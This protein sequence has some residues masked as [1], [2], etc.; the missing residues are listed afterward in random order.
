[1]A[2]PQVAGTVALMF[3]AAK[4]PLHIDETHRL[5]LGTAQWNPAWEEER[6]RFGSGYL[7]IEG[8]VDAARQARKNP[9]RRL[10][11]DREDLMTQVQEFSSASL[12]DAGRL[13]NVEI[14]PEG[15][16][17]AMEKFGLENLES[18]SRSVQVME[19]EQG[20]IRHE[21]GNGDLLN[22]GYEK[23]Q[24][25]PIE[26]NIGEEKRFVLKV[27]SYTNAR[28]SY[29][30]AGAIDSIMASLENLQLPPG[31]SDD[32]GIYQLLTITALAPGEAR[33]VLKNQE[34]GKSPTA[35]KT[36]L[37]VVQAERIAG[38]PTGG[39]SSL[40]GTGRKKAESELLS[41]EADWQEWE[42]WISKED[43]A[44]EPKSELI[45]TLLQRIEAME[46]AIYTTPL[47]IQSSSEWY[48]GESNVLI[49]ETAEFYEDAECAACDKTDQLPGSMV[50]I[51]DGLIE[52]GLVEGASET[53]I[54]QALSEANVS[55]W[56]PSPAEL[57]DVFATGGEQVLR[58]TMEGLYELVGLP[59]APL[60][61]PIE[62]GDILVRRA[63]GEGSLAHAALVDTPELFA[64]EDLLQEGLT[65]ESYTPGWYT[66]V[67]EGGFLPHSRAHGYARR[68]LDWNGRVMPGQLVLRPIIETDEEADTINRK[69]PE[70]IRWVQ[71][72]LNKILG[73]T[74]AVDGLLGP[75]TTQAIK[76]FQQKAGLG[77]DGIVGPKTEQGLIQAGAVPPPAAPGKGALVSKFSALPAEWQKR[78]QGAATLINEFAYDRADLTA[79]HRTVLSGLA[80]NTA[81]PVTSV[82][83]LGHTD[84]TGTD[85]YNM[86]LGL[87]RAD[88]AM[89]VLIDEI[90]K[91][92][93]GLVGKIDFKTFSLGETA[94]V[95]D[96]KTEKGRALNRRVAIFLNQ[97]AKPKPGTCFVPPVSS[98]DPTKLSI[99]AAGHQDF[100][101][102][103][104]T[105]L[106][107]SFKV[108]GRVFYPAETNGKGKPFNKKLAA[109]GPVPIVILA[110]GNHGIFS[111]PANRAKEKC[112]NVGGKMI[113]I[114]NHLGY[115]YFQ[116]MLAK[117]GIIS[118]SVNCNETNCQGGSPTNIRQRAGLILEA[119]KHFRAK[120]A[121]KDPIFGGRIDFSKTGLFGHSRGA[122]AVLVVPELLGARPGG[123]SDVVI[124]SV[125]SLAP[126]DNAASSGI[127]NGYA[128][129]VIL[130][131]GD[132]DVVTN[133][134]AKFY[135][136]AVPSPFKCQLYIHKTNHNF[137][138]REWVEDDKHGPPVLKRTE[139]E[140]L[141][142]VYGAAFYRNTLLGEPFRRFLRQDE[143][144]P[145]TPTTEVHIS[146]E[147]KGFLLV[148]DHENRNIS[149]N[150][151]SQPTQ[152]SGGLTAAEFDFSRNGSATFNDSFFGKTVGMVAQT[153]SAGGDYKTELGSPLDLTGKEVW[154][155]VA[156]VYN[157]S[158]I[159]A[160]ATGFQIGLE[161]ASGKVALIDS[162][163][164]I[165]G[166]PRPYDR[167]ADDIAAFKVDLT[168]TML[169]TLRFPVSCFA[170]ALSGFDITK[171]SAIHLRLDRND[172]R[173]LAF[174]QVQ[175]V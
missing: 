115:V 169:K 124:Q 26:L 27:D 106:G 96:E 173:S 41:P 47:E 159:P 1:M 117:M 161:D 78:C 2:A 132:G 4:S 141:L 36:L 64:R 101:A 98:D 174:D 35:Q 68:V 114:P 83:L 62:A 55:L 7:D 92:K 52:S 73:F 147:E 38:E 163:A 90:E 99:A 31:V 15:E 48:E 54:R 129:M 75:K 136:Q 5:L 112:T 130:P 131:A 113:P 81:Q 91:L 107:Q 100:N 23:D 63:L 14:Q 65:P 160:G 94:P 46:A 82:C 138:N 168:K 19:R 32:D 111:D 44:P 146:Y 158:S 45:D 18:E 154:L 86:N 77:V 144:P 119:I 157:G 61:K 166:L 20:N 72:S 74:L 97:V 125:I 156:E 66:R 3:E 59:G 102:G 80:Q 95:A 145:S 67:I 40:I 109:K 11:E 8:A 76:V 51:A 58:Q 89:K 39:Q 151:L 120:N 153:S 171:I 57:F 33:I 37:V 28:W 24:E 142:S 104:A 50:D 133:D 13:Q 110:H 134:G 53:L 22:A 34:K 105:I 150:A 139:H 79:K 88:N 148:D 49:R 93:P 135:D 84:N 9:S 137:F 149:L 21:V 103:S 126:T 6:N 123:I 108:F 25:K 162:N 127:P 56:M 175:I 29:T 152:Q 16:A 69:S 116:E 122:E 12:L 42:P 140:R 121:G 71:S 170:N 30:I 118:V 43:T 164:S 60:L 143:L 165:G 128:L 85:Q 167:R 172:K 10:I 70:Y 155:R 87:Q 17:V